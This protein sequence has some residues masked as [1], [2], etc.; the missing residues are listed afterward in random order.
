MKNETIKKKKFDPKE[1][2]GRAKL[3]RT[4]IAKWKLESEGNEYVWATKLDRVDIIRAGVPYGSIE[5]ISKRINIPIK[6]ILH[7]L[8]YLKLLTIKKEEKNPC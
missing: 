3:A 6:G 1:S 8:D 5:V 7:I 4:S 2:I